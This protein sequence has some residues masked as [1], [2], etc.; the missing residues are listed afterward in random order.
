MCALPAIAPSPRWL[1]CRSGAGPAAVPLRVALAQSLQCPLM[2][3]S[4]HHAVSALIH[5]QMAPRRLAMWQQ[6][7]DDD[8]E[9]GRQEQQARLEQRQRGSGSGSDTDADRGRGPAARGSPTGSATHWAA[10][11]SSWP[12][13]VWLGSGSDGDDS[14][15]ES[16]GVVPAVAASA[17]CV[18]CQ[19]RLRE[20]RPAPLFMLWTAMC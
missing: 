1:L 10:H 2:D 11:I 6:Q 14:E 16:A 17:A 19:R 4:S 7:Q 5:C 13:P 12:K 9:Q 3:P 18:L 15:D 20:G 8:Q